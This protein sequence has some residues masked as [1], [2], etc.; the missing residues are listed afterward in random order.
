MATSQRQKS[1]SL[2]LWDSPRTPILSCPLGFSVVHLT[3]RP[4]RRG[5][6]AATSRY[7]LRRKLF[8]VT[9]SIRRKL[10]L[11]RPLIGVG[12]TLGPT[13]TLAVKYHSGQAS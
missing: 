1:G 13:A 9:E 6:A 4:W 2:M 3:S 5:I 12:L 11:K 8:A 7:L 10:N